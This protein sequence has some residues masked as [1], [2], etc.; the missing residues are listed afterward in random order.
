MDASGRSLPLHGS[1]R[2][3]DLL[4]SCVLPSSLDRLD[5]ARAYDDVTRLPHDRAGPLCVADGLGGGLGWS[6]QWVDQGREAG[7]G[8]GEV[9]EFGHEHG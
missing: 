4:P 5:P 6:E 1:S 3:R 2:R 9:V 7:T 8:R